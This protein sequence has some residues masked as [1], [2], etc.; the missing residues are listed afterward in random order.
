MMIYRMLQT[1]LREAEIDNILAFCENFRTST[2]IGLER[3]DDLMPT[4]LLETLYMF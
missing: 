2:E 1:S 4:G 3:C